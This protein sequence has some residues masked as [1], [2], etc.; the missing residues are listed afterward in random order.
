MRLFN[1][2]SKHDQT[3]FDLVEEIL[4]EDPRIKI[5]RVNREFGYINV[6]SPS[7]RVVHRLILF[8]V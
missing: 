2:K 8:R 5:G 1:R 6:I 3:L 7:T 4:E